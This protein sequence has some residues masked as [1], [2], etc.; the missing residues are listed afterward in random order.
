M[1]V[2]ILLLTS[3]P[4][5]PRADPPGP[6][7]N[8]LIIIDP[9][10]LPNFGVVNA[11]V[12]DDRGFLWIA[13]SKGL[14]RYDGYEV[15]N[16]PETDGA[17]ALTTSLVKLDDGSFLL[18][19]WSGVWAFDPV[20]EQTRRVQVHD[21][22]LDQRVD[23]LARDGR[24]KI[25]VGMR[26]QGLIEFNHATGASI[27]HTANTGLSDNR[28]SALAVDDAGVIWIGTHGGGVNSLDPATG[29]IV[30]YRHL[31]NRANTISSDGI[32]CLYAERDTIWIG[33]DDGATVLH[34]QTG[35]ITRLRVSPAE[36]V[37]VTTITRDL[38]GVVWVGASGHG[39]FS[40]SEGVLSRFPRPS[41]PSASLSD[42]FVMELYMDP[43]SGG[44]GGPSFWVG[45]RG[46]TIDKVQI[47]M[48]PFENA[49][50]NKDSLELGIGAV[51]S[52]CQDAR[53]VTWVGLWG[54]GLDALVRTE[55]G[56]RR[57]AHYE[58]MPGTHNSLP[59]NAPTALLEDRHGSLWVGTNDGL[60][61]LDAPRRQFTVLKHIVGDSTSLVGRSI[62]DICEDRSGRIWVGTD[63]GL[64]RVVMGTPMTF[65]NFLHRAADTHPLGGRRISEIYED[66]SGTLWV[67]TYGKGLMRF[68]GRDRFIRYSHPGDTAGRREN[69][70]TTLHETEAGVF[71]L[72][73][74]ARLVRFDVRTGL[75]TGYVLDELRHVYVGAIES[76]RFGHI[77]L[78][79]ATGLL[80]L[81]PA[82]GTVHRYAATHGLPFKDI[83]SA[84]HRNQRGA[85]MVGGLDGFTEFAPESLR[86]S[87]PPPTIAITGFSIF[88]RPQPASF[89]AGA[90]VRLSYD[91][92]FFSFSFAALDFV[93]PAMNRY[94]Y[95]LFGV[96]PDW[97][98]G[99]HRNYASY[100]HLDPGEYEFQVRGANS[101]GIWNESGTSVRVIITPPYWQTWWFRILAGATVLGLLYAAYRYRLNK[102]LAIE[103][104]RLRIAGDLHDDIGSRLSSIALMSDVARNRVR[105]PMH[106][107]DALAKISTSAR[108]AASVLKDVVWTIDPECDTMGDMVQRMRD[109][110]IEQLGETV[111]SVRLPVE[112]ANIALDLATRRNL[113]LIYKEA[114]HN[115]QS[116]ARAS[117]VSIDGLLEDGTFRL[118]I[119]DNGVGFEPGAIQAGHGLKSMQQRAKAMGAELKFDSMPGGGATLTIKLKIPR[120][121]Y[122]GWAARRDITSGG[123]FDGFH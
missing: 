34:R 46:G 102:L 26:S 47:R 31:P 39:V 77:W 119:S 22:L 16:F 100:T 115:I 56:Y 85:L 113:L 35:A 121:R 90:T 93:D 75:F 67:S 37:R 96:D 14:C 114:L 5:S 42:M 41:R 76:D 24:G 79:T 40:Y 118:T 86:A 98:N 20:T 64:S 55:R 92:N 19:T 109:L 58:H 7:N 63:S 52:I 49:I 3:L 30:H 17:N 78:G 25:W 74:A 61:V 101:D 44:H 60:A 28:I 68:D 122:A 81:N 10:S 69:W 36:D 73:T 18:G 88:N 123:S 50:R 99:G 21:Q 1:L 4:V 62:T 106:G 107:E 70:V 87:R 116:H 97:V 8:H 84:F 94:A 6:Y 33:T 105:N 59:E 110:A 15:R 80:R 13:T 2:G 48:S 9:V 104:L 120:T 32:V 11:M 38:L 57:V 72:S 27:R 95:R 43:A 82:T 29:R 66:M 45:M 91:Q 89:L 54:G 53:G 111:Q 71:W 112:G 12:R 103:R 83:T 108:E 51:I 65:E 23:A 117:Q